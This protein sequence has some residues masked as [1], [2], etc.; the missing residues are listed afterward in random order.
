MLILK[1]L[2]IWAAE[3][4]SQAVLLGLLLIALLGFD[5]H[6]FGK[7]LLIYANAIL[8]MFF[9]TGYLVT[10]GI[11]RAVWR[12][13]RPW[14]Y[15]AVATVLFLIH[16]E[17]LSISVGSAFEP[18]DRVRIWMTGACIAFLSTLAGT[19]VLQKWMVFGVSN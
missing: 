12:G 6:A 10:T 9:L 17:V 15:S 18:R 11:S 3:I 14:L 13:R 8:V 16:F 5:R 2:T 7:S 4:I 19:A 1:R